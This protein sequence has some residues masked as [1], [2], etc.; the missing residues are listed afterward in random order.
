MTC[1]ATALGVKPFVFFSSVKFK[2][3]STLPVRAFTESDASSP[4][5]AY[6]KSKYEDEQG[7]QQVSADTGMEVFI[8]RPPLVY[9]PGVKANF[10]ALLRVVQRW[11]PL[12]LGLVRTQRSLVALGNLVDFIITC[13]SNP[14][15]ASQTFFVSDGQDLS[16][17]DLVRGMS[18]AVGVPARLLPVPVWAL[19]KGASLVGNANEIQRLCGNLQVDISKARICCAGCRPYLWTR[20]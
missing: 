7:L 11:R 16:T 12:P 19:Y 13:I 8:I 14:L 10:A 18:R 20:V 1:S 4:Q 5:D 2:G 15:A 6:G 9:G 17:T 3:E